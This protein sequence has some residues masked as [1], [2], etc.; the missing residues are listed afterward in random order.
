MIGFGIQDALSFSTACKYSNGGI[1]GTAFIKALKNDSRLES[2]KET[3]NL[4]ISAF[5]NKI[6]K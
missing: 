1:I 3:Y 4:N 5:V 2:S 6:R